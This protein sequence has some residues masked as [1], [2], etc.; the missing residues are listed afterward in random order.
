M[1][2]ALSLALL[3]LPAGGAEQSAS[4]NEA[5][6]ATSGNSPP[7]VGQPSVDA[8]AGLVFSPEFQQWNAPVC[9]PAKIGEARC[10][11]RVIADETG[12]PLAAS[13]PA[14]YG[15]AQILGAYGLSATAAGMPIIGIV[16]AY[17]DPTAA[18]DLNVFSDAVGVPELPA[19]PASPWP[20]AAPC[21]RKADESGGTDFPTVDDGWA[22]EISADVQIA[23]A[24]C[25]N[26]VI[27]LLE[28]NSNGSSDLFAALN[29]A[30]L[31]GAKAVSNSWG[32]PES[33]GEQSF[34]SYFDYPGIAF[35]FSTGDNGYGA[36]YPASSPYVTAVGGTTLTVGGSNQWVSETA[37]SGGGSGCSA[38][39][40]QP[41][42]Q[43]ALGLPGCANRMVADVSADA[44]P[45]TGWAIYD[46]TGDNG[47]AGWFLYGGTSAAAPLIAAV[48]ALGAVGSGV[49]ANSLPYALRDYGTN[50]RDIVGGSNGS[51]SPSY[52]CNAVAGYNGPTGLGTPL[53][54]G[55][56]GG[57]GD[58]DDDDN[59]DDNDDNDSADDD[60]DDNDN[61]DDDDNNEDDDSSADDD[62][63][64]SP[65]LPRLGSD[66]GS[67]G[68]GC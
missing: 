45:N 17:D 59:D 23:H 43:T 65:S 44:D 4:G 39:E 47:Q 33:P 3:P 60:D 42:F 28:A 19:C 1:S 27:L 25:Q 37:W 36:V 32:G 66:G 51:C 24:I 26:C 14:G 12:K 64:S 48:Y 13:A 6:P 63:D 29:E 40:P 54:V 46:S 5:A 18:A 20:P 9:G 49:M 15:P 67:S 10:H 35:A 2:V 41:A 68:C 34:D 7:A 11:A 56:F 62:D 38:Y 53:G 21:F 8:G 16:D 30:R 58:D 50:L 52:L 61:N 22:L 55:A 57:S 31:L